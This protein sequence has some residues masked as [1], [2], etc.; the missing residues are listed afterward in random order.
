MM[1]GTAFALKVVADQEDTFD[2]K[3]DAQ[4]AALLSRASA[5]SRALPDRPVDDY[6]RQVSDA[7]SPVLDE[8]TQALNRTEVERIVRQRLG[9]Q[10]FREALLSYWG[11]A[12]AVTGVDIPEVLRASHTK[13]WAD[14]DTD[15]ERLD[16]FNGFLLSANL[17]ALFDRHLISFDEQGSI[18]ISKALSPEQL[19]S[20]GIAEG[21][22]LRWVAPE[23]Q[24]YLTAHRQRFSALSQGSPSACRS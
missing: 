9:Q 15:N 12:C 16:V 8:Q 10:R 17:D 11:A 5:L 21:A 24:R 14:C 4:L 19:R 20:L 23:H 7:L 1:R 3:N 22:R 6:K 2:V 13:P 18:L